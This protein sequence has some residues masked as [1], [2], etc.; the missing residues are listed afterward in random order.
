MLLLSHTLE[1]R[2]C[3]AVTAKVIVLRV[4]VNVEKL[5]ACAT[6]A[7]IRITRVA[8]TADAQTHAIVLSSDTVVDIVYEPNLMLGSRHIRP[9]GVHCRYSPILGLICKIDTILLDIK[10]GQAMMAIALLLPAHHCSYVI[11]YS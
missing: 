5:S 6:L 2:E 10:R 9:A 1:D 7:A 3:C 11:V 4:D 8:R